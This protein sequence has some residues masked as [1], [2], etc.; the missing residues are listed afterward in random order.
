M[1]DFKKNFDVAVKDFDRAVGLEKLKAVEQIRADVA[2]IM[3]D[4]ELLGEPSTSTY[5]IQNNNRLH[6][7]E[8]P[9]SKS[10]HGCPF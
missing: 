1:G 9:R 7:S 8:G 4:V 10:G 6:T 3:A 2:Q 5:A